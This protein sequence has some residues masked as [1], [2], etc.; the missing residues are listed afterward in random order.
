MV[1]SGKHA[2]KVKRNTLRTHGMLY[3]FL[4][5][6]VLV[7]FLFQYLP[8]FSNY[9]A[10][11]DYKFNNG[12]FGLASPFVG[13]KNFAFIT[14]PS[15]WT[16]VGRTLLYSVTILFFSFP[17]PLILALLLNEIQFSNF[18]KF[19]QT[20]SYIP[21][22]VSWVT[23]AG[24]FYLFLSTDRSGIV[25]N[26]MENLFNK[27]RV[28][29]MQDS[30]Y[31]LL[32]LV[33]SQVWKEIGWGTILY[34]AALTTVDPQLYEASM[35]DGATRWQRCLY[36]TLPSLMSTTSIILIFSCGSI[37]SSNFDQVFNMQN[38]QIRSQTDT[39]NVHTYYRGVINQ[40]YSYAAAVGLFQGLVS[41]VLVMLTNTLSKSLTDTGII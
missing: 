19:V 33:V 7:V 26:I 3:M 5:P 22:F 11:L 6:A 2:G 28:S 39:I 29:Y 10:F 38:V 24:L 16:L 1:L 30:S 17:G 21:H 4:V 23:V 32:F 36:I 9:I 25:N 40:Q 31:F 34:L 41:F 27:P 12:W 35:V 37:F 8:M 18:K 20:V 15:F 13:F 14:Q